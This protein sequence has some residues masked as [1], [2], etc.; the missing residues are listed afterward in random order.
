MQTLKSLI[1]FLTLILSGCSIF[2]DGDNDQSKWSAEKLYKDARDDMD[3]GRYESAISSFEKLESRYP[4]G[5][6]G[7]QAQLEIAYAHYRQD[8]KD[9]AIAAADLFIKLHPNHAHVDYAYYLKGL[10]NFNDRTGTFDAFSKQDP[11]ERDP[12]AAQ[13]SFQAFRELTERFP[14]SIYAED[15]R[16]RMKYLVNSLSRYEVDVARYYYRRGAFVAAADRAQNAIKTYPGTPSREEALFIMM[17]SY[18]ALNLNDLR[19]DTERVLR[20]NFPESAYLTG[21]FKQEE[22]WWKFW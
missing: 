17:K 18:E 2:P 11:A 16:A 5:A 19:N 12:K 1:L 3:S 6:Y 22:A 4:F 9:E 8:Q 15:A 7:E 10:I 21:K 20:Q 14:N 13:N